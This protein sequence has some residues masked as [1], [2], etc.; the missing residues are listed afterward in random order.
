[1]DFLRK[2]SLKDNTMNDSDL[3]N[4]SNCPIYPGD[5]LINTNEG[6]INN[7]DASTEGSHWTCFSL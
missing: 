4:I 1:M 6:F 5:S 3:K 7:N 2:Y